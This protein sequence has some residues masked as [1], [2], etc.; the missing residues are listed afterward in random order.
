MPSLVGQ[1]ANFGALTGSGS[2]IDLLPNLERQL[3]HYSRSS[4]RQ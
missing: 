1:L 2:M 4:G 3:N